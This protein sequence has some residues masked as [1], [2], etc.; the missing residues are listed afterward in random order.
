MEQL[1]GFDL[2]ATVN[3]AA[4]NMDVCNYLFETRL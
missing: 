2:L 4:M 1:G 3:G